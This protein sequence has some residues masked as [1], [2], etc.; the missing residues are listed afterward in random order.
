MPYRNPP[1]WLCDINLVNAKPIAQPV[2]QVA[3]QF[4]EKLA[5]PIK[6]AVI[7]KDYTAF[8]VTMGHPNCY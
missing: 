7:C 4:K 6:G 5:D 2:R 1:E 3:P 8:D